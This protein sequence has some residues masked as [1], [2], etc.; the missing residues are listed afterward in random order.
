MPN[1]G[2]HI[3]FAL[4]AAKKLGNPIVDEHLGSYLLGC[5]T[6]DL[7]LLIGWDR[8]KT[9]FF[10]LATDPVGAGVEALF[11]THP[12]LAKFERLTHGTIAFMTGYISHLNA[13]ERWIVNVYRRFF[14]VNS[15][16]VDDPMANV[17]DRALQFELDRR[18]RANIEDLEG[19]LE[20]IKIWCD[21]VDI[22][23]IDQDTLR[24]WQDVVVARSSRDLPWDRFKGY[25]L[26]VLPP[27]QR[28]DGQRVA[29]VMASVPALLERVMSHVPEEELRGFRQKA[30][31]D[32]LTVAR[33]YLIE[34]H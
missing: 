23:F 29:E 34:D 33:G 27:E 5:T 2:L 15:T 3:G 17:L 9:H 26:R 4:E 22:G 18:E 28:E 13:D 12:H 16:L 32:F 11:R 31:D 10:K 21:G 19:A 6:P 25:V 7:R 24:Q 20:K 8:E 1:M 14:G 30:L